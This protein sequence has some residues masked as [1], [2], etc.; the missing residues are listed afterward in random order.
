M[1]RLWILEHC[2]RGVLLILGSALDGCLLCLLLNRVSGLPLASIAALALLAAVAVAALLIQARAAAPSALALARL[3]DRRAGTRDLFASA[4]EFKR[5]PDRFG[6]LG[7]LTCDLA[8]SRAAAL[9]LRP[10]WSPGSIRNWVALGSAAAVLLAAYFGAAV[11]GLSRNGAPPKQPDAVAGSGKIDT[12]PKPPLDEPKAVAPAAEEAQP[13]TK[14]S[15]P[16]AA[17]EPATKITTEM[18]DKYL[19][20]MPA[21]QDVDLTGVTPVR[22]DNDE[23]SGKNNPQNQPVPE[24]IDPV[25]LDSALLKDLEGAKKKKDESSG[26]EGGVDIAVMSDKGDTKVK[27]K[28]GGKQGGESLANAVS[29]DPRGEATRMAPGNRPAKKGMQVRSA[30]RTLSKQKGEELPMGLLDF[31]AALEKLKSEP[32]VKPDTSPLAAGRSP[33]RVIRQESLSDDAAALTQDYFEQL[34]KADR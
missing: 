15:E 18:I 8:R 6:L 7:A 17:A 32:A 5:E 24:K 14:E 31:M 21:N 16:E 19:A 20:Q 25:K 2:A 28:E 30:A 10:R 12:P 1:R 22:W 3:L 34:R 26:K 23:A 9:A 27:G 29:K 33:D 13:V 4:V 11:I